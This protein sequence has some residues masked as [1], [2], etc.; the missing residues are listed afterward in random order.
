MVEHTSHIPY[1]LTS[2]SRMLCTVP[3]D[4]MCDMAGIYDWDNCDIGMCLKPNQALAIGLHLTLKTN[5]EQSDARSQQPASITQ[6]LFIQYQ[7]LP[8]SS[9]PSGS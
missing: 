2:S 1:Q 8:I 6:S 5:A 3:P 9:S 4:R 7:G